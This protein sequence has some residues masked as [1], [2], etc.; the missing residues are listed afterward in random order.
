MRRFQRIPIE[1][2]PCTSIPYPF[3]VKKEHIA[4][5][6]VRTDQPVYGIIL[7]HTEYLNDGN[8]VGQLL[9]K[10]RCFIAMQLHHI[11]SI[12]VYLLH[13]IVI[14]GIDKYPDLTQT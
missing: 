10:P 11:Q 2:L 14:G 7:S 6:L 4:I 5:I 13:D 8:I 3:G 1:F 9:T 12:T